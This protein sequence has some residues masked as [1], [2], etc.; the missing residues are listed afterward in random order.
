MTEKTDLV[1]ESILISQQKLLWGHYAVVDFAHF[2]LRTNTADFGSSTSPV[3][4]AADSHHRLREDLASIFSKKLLWG[5]YGVVDFLYLG[6]SIKQEDGRAQQ[7]FAR[8]GGRL[9]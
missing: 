9:R 5:H 2:Q 1:A 4:S 7:E 3:E 8:N 6:L